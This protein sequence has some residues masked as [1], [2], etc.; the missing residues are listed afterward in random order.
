MQYITVNLKH[1]VAKLILNNCLKSIK[2][3]SG[4]SSFLT[5]SYNE[6]Q[7]INH[8]DSSITVYS[9][10]KWS[11]SKTKKN[12]FKLSTFLASTYVLHGERP[13]QVPRRKEEEEEE[14]V[15]RERKH[16]KD[17]TRGGARQTGWSVRHPGAPQGGRCSHAVVWMRIERMGCYGCDEDR[18][19]LE[20][21]RRNMV[22]SPHAKT[23]RTRALRGSTVRQVYR[24]C[25]AKLR[26][27]IST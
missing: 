10:K 21:T 1:S 17:W 5:C 19:R 4:L 18:T 16:G 27:A 13:S 15:E 25:L 26:L 22:A 2:T 9:F 12:F 14:K 7:V 8:D 6:S 24:W 11:F 23:S 20:K 3:N